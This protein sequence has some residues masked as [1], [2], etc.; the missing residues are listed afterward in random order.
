MCAV[1]HD[2]HGKSQGGRGQTKHIFSRTSIQISLVIGFGNKC[3]HNEQTFQMFSSWYGYTLWE[4]QVHAIV[5]H[6][7]YIFLAGQWVWKTQRWDFLWIQIGMWCSKHAQQN[8]ESGI[9]HEEIWI[10]EKQNI[11]KGEIYNMDSYSKWFTDMIY[12][13]SADFLLP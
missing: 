9:A 4:A 13:T 3:S 11:S 7:P 1:H 2:P 8:P 12:C 10:E 5:S 6:L